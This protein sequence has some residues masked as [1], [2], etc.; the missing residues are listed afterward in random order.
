MFFSFFALHFFSFKIF[1]S[2]MYIIYK[3][4]SSV[5]GELLDISNT[6]LHEMY[7]C[8]QSG[9]KYNPITFPLCSSASI[10]EHSQV[11]VFDIYNVVQLYFEYVSPLSI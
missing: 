2:L 5:Y 10:C 11:H 1:G 4:F 8:I 3:L 6:T 7:V 9:N